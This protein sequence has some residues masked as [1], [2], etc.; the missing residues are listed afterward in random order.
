[1]PPALALST[2]VQ[3]LWNLVEALFGKK[4]SWHKRVGLTGIE[5]GSRVG[6]K[7]VPI[8][9]YQED[10]VIN[11]LSVSHELL[12]LWRF[13]CGVPIV[14]VRTNKFLEGIMT[15][16]Q[17]HY[18]HLW[19]YSLQ[20][21][22]PFNMHPWNKPQTQAHV[23]ES[24]EQFKKESGSD[25]SWGTACDV[26]LSRPISEQVNRQAVSIVSRVQAI[27]TDGILDAWRWDNL[28]S[29]RSTA[30][31]FEQ[32]LKI[33]G[34]DIETNGFGWQTYDGDFAPKL[35]P[36]HATLPGFSIS[37]SLSGCRNDRRKLQE[38]NRIRHGAA[39][40]GV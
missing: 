10:S 30:D 33:I 7:G 19:I 34:F 8:I 25:L 4:I 14:C 12:H 18:E 29:A 9:G 39:S 2:E 36:A 35:L 3:G 15:D 13:G 17:I 37:E 26:A 32:V 24:I 20:A 5:L 31:T 23:D 1:M 28:V 22:P 27:K 21:T 16:I 38:I 40:I 6:D 11:D